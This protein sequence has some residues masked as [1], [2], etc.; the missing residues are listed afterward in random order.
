MTSK[1][2]F[3]K[4][5]KQD[6]KRRIWYPILAFITYFLFLEVILLLKL[7]RLIRFPKAY[8]YDAITYVKDYFFGE[9]AAKIA[10]IVCI[11]AFLCGISNYAYLHS[12]I[13]I[14]TY[15]SLP[16]SRTQL[17]WSKYL[18]GILQFL[19]PFVIHVFICAGL[20]A[21]RDAFCT[22]TVFSMLSYIGI[23]LIVFILAYSAAV[24]AVELTGNIIISILGTVVLFSYSM[25]I[26]VLMHLLSER[27]YDTYIVYGSQENIVNDKVW[28][29]SPLS[30]IWQLFC[31]PDPSA[32]EGVFRY[33]TSYL[34]ILIIGAVFYSLAAYFIY[35]KRASESAGKSIAFGALEP[36]IKTICVIPASL[37][38]AIFFGE[39]S[40]NS[41]NEK[42]F[43]FGLVFGFTL[44][45]ILLEIIFRMD[46]RGAFMH[47]KQFLFNAACT[48]LIFTVFR[49]DVLGYDTYVPADTQLHSCAV[50]I[51]YLFPLS[52]RIGYSNG[53][54]TYLSASEYRMKNME[55][56]GNPS[57]MELA[58]KAAKEGLTYQKFDYYD[59][60]EETPEYIEAAERQSSYRT[61]SFGYKLLNGKILYREYI[62]DIAKE[63][64]LE[65]LAEI[66]NDY[67]YKLG[68][69]PLF[70]DGWNTSFNIL[71]CESNYKEKELALTPEKQA[72]LL[73]TYQKE[74][75]K[76]TLDTVM[77]TIPTGLITFES[78]TKQNTY[79]YEN[80]TDEMFV[81][82]Q[83]TETIALIKEYGFD[84]EEKLTPDE[85]EY[86]IVIG[87]HIDSQKMDVS[88]DESQK[89]KYTDKEQI[90]Q[91]LDNIINDDFFW[92]TAQYANYYNKKYTIN[93]RAVEDGSSFQYKFI[94]DQI[95]DFIR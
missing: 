42:W 19:L 33:N 81:Y 56:Q 94:K 35:L 13:Q 55:I 69:T 27:F 67:D 53:D 3:F 87:P 83:F 65:L 82:P 93:V 17:F 49:N 38:V 7:E 64:T 50:S 88:V 60:I 73:E 86:I 80:Y 84:M 68:A 95:P 63:D 41:N 34:W 47:K 66:F 43:L 59:G 37:F 79:Y 2:L 5:I 62:I 29:F 52:Q 76:L 71:K 12:K 15:H 36:V 25:I 74:Y 31:N 14:D 40:T 61:I 21:G 89:T 26:A 44:L 16:V 28:C 22:E 78:R 70:Q 75:M 57:V 8:S 11:S 32:A 20:A 58:R 54:S 9:N 23:L 46:L 91:I 51:S 1:N 6:F 10:I 18:T 92:Q 85:I 4:L 72:K 48:A 45:C 77:N 30:M 90:Q 24:I 39:L